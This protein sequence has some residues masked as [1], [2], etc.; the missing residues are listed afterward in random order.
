[1]KKKKRK[2]K[3]LLRGTRRT[4]EALKMFG[5]N[6]VTRVPMEL[7]PTSKDQLTSYTS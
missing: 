4:E 3:K 7:G 1:L 5:A 2:K 6:F